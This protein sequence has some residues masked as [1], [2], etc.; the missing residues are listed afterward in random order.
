MES[1]LVAPGG[2][3]P[4]V[5]GSLCLHSDFSHN[6]VHQAAQDTHHSHNRS[7]S[8]SRLA[9]TSCF[10]FFPR[11]EKLLQ[12]LKQFDRMF[13]TGAE[14]QIYAAFGESRSGKLRQKSRPYRYIGY[15]D[16]PASGVW[17]WPRSTDGEE[18]NQ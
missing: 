17:S 4:A 6:F 8:H 14:T 10:L 18:F 9:D 12:C 16:D 2:Y 5:A 11:P 7:L 3:W 13:G 1:L 15:F